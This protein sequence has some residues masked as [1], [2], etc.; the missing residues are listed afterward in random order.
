MSNS[1]DLITVGPPISIVPHLQ[2]QSITDQ[3]QSEKNFSEN[4]QKGKLN[5]LCA[6]N[7]LQSNC[8]VFTNYLQRIYTVLGVISHLEII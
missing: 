1:E 7:H 2:I 4:F 8:N 6:G 3:K 5:L